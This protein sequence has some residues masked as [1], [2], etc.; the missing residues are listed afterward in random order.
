MTP[1]NC[2]D[3][4]EAS[5]AMRPLVKKSP[6]EYNVRLSQA[7]EAEIYIKREDLQTVRSYKIRGAFTVMNSLSQEELSKGVVCAS[8]GNHA[9]GLALSCS[10]FKV[11]GTIFM[12]RTTP[13]QKIERTKQFGTTYVSI[14]LIGDTFDEANAAALQFCKESGA[15][16]VHPFNDKRTMTGQ[17]SLAIEILED[18]KKPID[19]LFVPIGG[20]GLLSGVGSYFTQKSPQTCIV[21]VEPSGAASMK[22]S[23]EE[24]KVVALENI[25]TFVDGASV[26][27]VGDL[28]FEIC[29][30]FLRRSVCVPENRVCSTLLS[31]LKEEGIIL[32]P[33][34]ALAIDALKD[35]KMEIKGKRVVCIASGGNFDFD[36]LA[37]VKERSLKFE[38]LKKYFLISFAQR[39]GALKEFLTHLGPNDDIV[40][41]EYLK[42]TKRERGPALVGIETSKKDQFDTLKKKLSAAQITYEDITDNQ[43]F[44]DFLI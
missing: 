30:S 20:G 10:F 32:E 18:L 31:F 13:L 14:K 1:L 37:E 40:R 19:Y 38:G 28:S 34:G 25:D 8:A 2:K 7:Y 5:I 43:L 23:L 4:E 11:K 35:M 39:P 44:F 3:I 41:F 26:A 42:K 6:L 17:G 21:G 9:Q 15:T 16:F 29:S 27:K 12:P 36:R 22:A 33:A 24:G